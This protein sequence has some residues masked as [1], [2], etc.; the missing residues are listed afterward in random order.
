MLVFPQLATQKCHFFSSDKKEV[1]V[2]PF[3]IFFVK[4]IVNVNQQFFFITK[5]ITRLEFHRKFLIVIGWIFREINSPLVI[6]IWRKKCWF[7][8]KNHVCTHDKFTLPEIFFRQ[9]NY[10]VIS[11]VL[12]PLLS[13]KFC[14][15][16][17]R[18]N[19]RNFHTVRD[20]L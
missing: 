13:R 19:F 11:L 1:F 17:V 6:L 7:F 2:C 20:S 4:S 3:H 12:K 8:H 9:I 18:V 16:C 5:E 14:Q 10:F 15:K